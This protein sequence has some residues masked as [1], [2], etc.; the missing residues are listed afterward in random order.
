MG[1]SSCNGGGSTAMCRGIVGLP[2]RCGP[3]CF[4]PEGSRPVQ[5]GAILVAPAK[6]G[7]ACGCAGLE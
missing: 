4:R 1:R 5:S 3:A 6:R 7:T 2:R